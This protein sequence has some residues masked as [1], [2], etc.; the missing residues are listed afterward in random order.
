M[1]PIHDC[2]QKEKMLRALLV[3]DA[4]TL[5][6]AEFERSPNSKEPPTQLE[7]FISDV[8]CI[9]H[10][11]HG[12]CGSHSTWLD[13]IEDNAKLLKE[14]NIMDLEKVL[15]EIEEGK[16]PK[17]RDPKGLL[18]AIKESQNENDVDH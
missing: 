17:Q 16:R 14:A 2:D 13:R 1:K 3:I 7:R 8:Y 4:M 11:A 10:A 9:A 12:M 15:K 5:G 18:H 6:M